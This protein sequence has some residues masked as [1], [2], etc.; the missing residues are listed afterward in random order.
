MMTPYDLV[1]VTHVSYLRKAEMHVLF[2]HTSLGQGSCVP[3]KVS[4]LMSHKVV[5][6][7]FV[8]ALKC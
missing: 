8:V 3:L 1:G 5:F 4:D 7:V 2:A 6:V